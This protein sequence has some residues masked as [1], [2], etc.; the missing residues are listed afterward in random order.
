M[1]SGLLNFMQVKP[2]KGLLK[3]GMNKKK[4]EEISSSS[5]GMY[6]NMM[7]FMEQEE[8]LIKQGHKGKY[9]LFYDGKCWG[10]LNEQEPLLSSFMRQFR[11]KDCYLDRIGGE[12]VVSNPRILYD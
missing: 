10:I 12:R 1:V 7:V 5:K 3:D 6:K 11:N 9:A 2:R 8:E 4:L